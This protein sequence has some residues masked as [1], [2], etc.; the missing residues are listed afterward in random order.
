MKTTTVI[1][2]LFMLSGVVSAQS[3]DTSKWVC[4]NLADSGYFLYEGESIFGSQ[5]CR[6]IPQTT[7]AESTATL[8]SAISKVE[9]PKQDTPIANSV[10]AP[11]RSAPQATTTAPAKE[12]SVSI[13]APKSDASNA[14]SGFPRRW[15]SLTAGN[16][17]TLR[18]EGE[19]IYA[20]VALPEAA[21]KA[22]TFIL[23]EAKKDGDK[24]VGKTS[25]RALKTQSGPICSVT[26]PIEFTLVTTDRIEG[27]SFTPPVGA[28][29]N[30]GTCSYSPAPNW[31]SFIWIPVR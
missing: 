23:T 8:P 11:V 24:Y 17:R 21:A 3:P 20:E 10:A 15:K 18:F 31:Q 14:N 1:L 30:W 7:P 5:A 4:R 26:E 12:V 2:S 27:R 22:G 9:T 28:A 16:V 25:G 6:P 13:E 19:Y 29:L